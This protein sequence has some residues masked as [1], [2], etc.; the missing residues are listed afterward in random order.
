[1]N[2][3]CYM[4]RSD[5]LLLEKMRVSAQIYIKGIR[6]EYVLDASRGERCLA[7]SA[8]AVK[9]QKPRGGEV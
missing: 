8:H 6:R 9:Y 2:A 4:I 7:V 3:D 5:A 1:M